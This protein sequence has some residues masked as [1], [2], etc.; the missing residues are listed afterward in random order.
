MRLF[1]GSNIDG[2]NILEP[3][4]ADHDRPYI[5][6]STNKIVAGFY[7]VNAVER[8]YYWFP[9]TINKHG[10]PVY[11]EL[12]PNALQEVSIGREGFIYEVEVVSDQFIPHSQI[13]WVKLGTCPIS[14]TCCEY[15]PDAWE[16]FLQEETKN[17]LIIRHF[18]TFTQKEMDQYYALIV[19]YLI[20]KNMIATPDSSYARFIKLKFPWVWEIYEKTSLSENQLD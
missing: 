18:G 7:M 5:Y 13:P 19:R 12:Y 3:H 16:W 1:H 4:L 20:Q 9:Y 14:V 6:L 10:I 15:I 2:I 17:N 11:D 8:P